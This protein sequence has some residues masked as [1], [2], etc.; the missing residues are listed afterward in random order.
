M[1]TK[2]TK[3]VEFTKTIN[4]ALKSAKKA[5]EYALH[6]TEEV[7]TDTITMASQWQKV[8][9]KALKGGVKLLDNQQNLVLDTLEM[10]KKHLVNGK[11]RFGKLFA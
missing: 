6:T 1:S 7:V 4:T 5:N 3:K 10:Y 2:K 11:R 8:T 9:E